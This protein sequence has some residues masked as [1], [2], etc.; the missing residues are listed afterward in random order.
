MIPPKG[1]TTD[2]VEMEYDYMWADKESDV[3]IMAKSYGLKSPQPIMTN[4]TRESGGCTTMF[5]S[6][7]KYYLWNAMEGEIWEIVTSMNLVDI[8]TQ[9]DKLGLGSLK[10]AKVP[11]SFWGSKF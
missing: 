4:S 8:I 7:S 11:T 5:Q 6:G 3:H 1:W 2:K 9:I 10:V